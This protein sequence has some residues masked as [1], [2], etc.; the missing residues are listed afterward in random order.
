VT[1]GVLAVV[2]VVIVV[3]GIAVM[4]ITVRLSGRTGGQW[5]QTQAKIERD[6]AAEVAAMQE[7]SD[8]FFRPEG[9]GRREDDL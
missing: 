5:P 6:S 1:G 4:V 7:E 2:V 8:E 3:L 9:P